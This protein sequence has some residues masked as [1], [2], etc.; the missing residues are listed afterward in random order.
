MF[1]L[2]NLNPSVRFYWEEDGEWVDFRL[3]PPEKAEEFRQ[4]V[5]IKQKA[6]YRKVS[7]G[8]A[9][10]FEYFDVTEQKLKAFSELQIDYQIAD[11]HLIDPKNNK[12]PCTKENKVKL[13]NG[14]P[15]FSSWME[16]CL[17]QMEQDAEMI[18]EEEEKN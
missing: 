15:V 17:A 7:K 4:A 6:E 5:G 3:L 9:Q 8:P 11:W 10:R 12:I 1:D 16:R 2:E 14:S 18:K 13:V